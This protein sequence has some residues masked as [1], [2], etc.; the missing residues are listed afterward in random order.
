M[1]SM[2]K[3]MFVKILKDLFA[4][5]CTDSYGDR[6]KNTKKKLNGARTIAPP[7]H[8]FAWETL[9]DCAAAVLLTA[10]A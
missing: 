6:S 1:K 9:S 2:S 5:D 8:A 4:D 7:F 3:D 10:A